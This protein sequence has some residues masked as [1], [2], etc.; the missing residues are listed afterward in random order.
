MPL[1]LEK[2]A[3]GE[4][5]E[6]HGASESAGVRGPGSGKRLTQAPDAV[7]VL[8]TA[9]PFCTCHTLQNSCNSVINNNNNSEKPC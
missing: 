3:T 1:P 5:Q 2:R 4:G 9:G 7:R 6:G 8:W